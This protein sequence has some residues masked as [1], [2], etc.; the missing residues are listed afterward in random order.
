[1]L[2]DFVPH[3]NHILIRNLILL[4]DYFLIFQITFII[5][6]HSGMMDSQK[7]IANIQCFIIIIYMSNF[8]V[9]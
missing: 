8:N 4:M 6:L 7:I 9:A 2:S 5:G 3:L 1:M